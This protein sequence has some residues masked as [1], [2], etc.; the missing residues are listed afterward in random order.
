MT[1]LLISA[2]SL[3]LNIVIYWANIAKT[4]SPDVDKL[5]L[6]DAKLNNVAMW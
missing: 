3:I 1:T 4:H 6:R 5:H 2:S